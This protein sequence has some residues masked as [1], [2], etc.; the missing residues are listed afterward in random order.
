MAID[1]RTEWISH[2]GLSRERPENTLSAFLLALERG[3]DGIELDVHATRDGMLV[4]HH[5]HMLPAPFGAVAHAPYESD[6][7]DVRAIA[8][9][10]ARELGGF[11]VAGEPIPTLD[12]VLS[13]VGGRA[14]LYIELKA[15]R[16]E[17]L[18]AGALADARDLSRYAVHSFD[19]RAVR[20]MRELAPELATGIL[21]VSYLLDPA[22]TLRAAGARDYWAEWQTI[23]RALVN[24]VHAAGGRVI[25]WTVNDQAAAAALIA[26]GVDGICTDALIGA[27]RAAAV[28]DLQQPS[29]ADAASPA[30]TG[31]RPA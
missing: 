7:P 13:A 5:D 27:H 10:S 8:E 11:S 25:A 23:D 22:A 30:R 20:R 19:H 9:L 1:R 12:Q 18:V 26:L 24:E 29:G 21:T 15:R 17:S 4:V 3:A 16:I 31:N 2:R 6:S 14:V 28:R